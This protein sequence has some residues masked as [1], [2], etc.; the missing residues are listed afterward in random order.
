MGGLISSEIDK[1]RTELHKAIEEE[2][3]L[4]LSITRDIRDAHLSIANALERI[5]VTG[6]A[7][8]SARENLRVEVLK[9]DTGAG[10]STD[11]IDA[12]TA[13]LRAEAD[14]TTR[15]SLTRRPQWCT[16]GKP[17]ERNGTKRGGE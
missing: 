13:M 16:S 5:E 17:R 10:T 4:R 3:S 2:R 8:E 15:L 6:K 14:Y 7:I 11:V 1:E 12:R 9:Y